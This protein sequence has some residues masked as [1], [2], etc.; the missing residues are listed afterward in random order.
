MLQAAMESKA[1][2]YGNVKIVINDAES[3]AMKQTSQVES[4]MA[5]GADAIIVCPYDGDACAPAIKA[6]VDAGIPTIC[7]SSNVNGDHGQVWVGSGHYTAGQ[8]EAQYV[9]DQLGGEGNVA[10]LRGPLGHFAEQ[11]RAAGYQDVWDAN[12]GINVVFDQTANWQRDEAMALVE[13]WLSTGTEINAI[14]CQND[15]MALGAYEAVKA[16]GKESE[17][18]VY[19]IDAIKDALDSISAGGLAGTCFQ[20]AIGQGATAVELAMDAIA[21]KEISDTD[22]PFEL[23]TPENVESYYSRIS[24]S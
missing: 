15:A 17:I 12:P 8:I 16:A 11:D 18:P 23:V 7:L 6:S 21:G 24:L 14:C 2:E 3:D 1:A 9:V 5:Q 10:V 20:D 19:G 22:I 13:N 4:F